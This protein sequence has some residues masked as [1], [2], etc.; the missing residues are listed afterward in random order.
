MRFLWI[1][2]WGFEGDVLREIARDVGCEANSTFCSSLSLFRKDD[3]DLGRFPSAPGRRLA[4]LLAQSSE[5][6]IIIAW[7]L[8]GELAIEASL[9]LPER[10]SALV[11]LS[12]EPFFLSDGSRDGICERRAAELRLFQAGIQESPLQTLLAFYRQCGSVLRK[13]KT[14][15]ESVIEKYSS[16]LSVALD[17]LRDADHRERIS[18]L[19]VPCVSLRGLKDRILPTI[20]SQQPNS[21]ASFRVESGPHAIAESNGREIAQLVKL[22]SSAKPK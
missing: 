6:S 14:Y 1:S 2:G 16:V 11:L 9:I 4:E 18:T 12:A 3:R 8:G 20:P 10:V 15:A 5:P 21:L 13:E 17:Y 7:S 22:L 19:Q